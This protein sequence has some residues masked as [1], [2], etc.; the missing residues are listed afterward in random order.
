MLTL[1]TKAHS[2]EAICRYEEWLDRTIK[3]VKYMRIQDGTKY[4]LEIQH[5][6][7]GKINHA[8]NFERG[9]LWMEETLYP[10]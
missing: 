5:R 9:E 4:K 6:S 8:I 7:I 10:K 1:I 2:E 3:N